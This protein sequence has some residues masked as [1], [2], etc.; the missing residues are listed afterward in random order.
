MTYEMPIPVEGCPTCQG[1]G[2]VY[3][4]PKH[5]PNVYVAEA[6]HSG[7]R[8]TAMKPEPFQAN[9]SCPLLEITQT[10]LVERIFL[11][12]DQLIAKRITNLLRPHSRYWHISGKEYNALKKRYG[13]K[14]WRP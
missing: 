14:G 8:R 4:C 1:T 11:Q 3:S 12:V 7:E 13:V 2:G 5:S 9:K 6:P 10:E